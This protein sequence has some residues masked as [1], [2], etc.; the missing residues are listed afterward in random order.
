[1][2]RRFPL[3]LAG[4]VL[5]SAFTAATAIAGP[6]WISIELP[7]NP[8]DPS[9]RD[10]YLLVHTFH[11]EQETRE[12]VSGQAIGFVNGKRTVIE[13]EFDRTSRPGVLA[14]R[15]QWPDQGAWVLALSV[16]PRDGQATALVGIGDDGTVRFVKVPTTRDAARGS[17]PSRVTGADV[18]AALRLL[19]GG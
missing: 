12:L 7:A 2:S 16:G 11:H 1:M 13:L 19:A 4:L 5:C 8:M 10:A 14:L 18:D 9:T 17:W 3:S 6:P 15:K